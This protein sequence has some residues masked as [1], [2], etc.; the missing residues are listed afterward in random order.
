MDIATALTRLA[1]MEKALTISAPIA[2]SIKRVHTLPPNRGQALADT[3]CW[4]NSWQLSRIESGLGGA[5]GPRHEYYAV[6]AQ[7]FVSDADINRAASIATAFLP[8]FIEALNADYTL[9]DAVLTAE[10]RGGDPTLALLEWGGQ[11]YAGLDLFV[12]LDLANV[13]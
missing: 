13:P 11:S 3:P 6:H 5:A 2:A 9:G 8:K 4:I 1:T 12:D 7:L 10:L